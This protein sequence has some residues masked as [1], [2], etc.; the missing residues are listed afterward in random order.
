MVAR[1]KSSWTQSKQERCLLF[2]VSWII[3]ANELL[4]DYAKRNV[5]IKFKKK[6]YTNRDHKSVKNT[7]RGTRSV[8]TM[9]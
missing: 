3:L 8:S 5:C 9:F 1:F 7:S 2:S 4:E 6:I